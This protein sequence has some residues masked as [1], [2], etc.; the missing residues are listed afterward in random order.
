MRSA[1]SEHPAGGVDPALSLGEG[2]TPVVRLPALE[3]H[4][5]GARLWCKAEHLN[6]TGSYKD[7]LAVRAVTVARRHGLSGILGTSSGNGAAAIA[8]YGARAGLP[9]RILT[10]PGAPAA[11]L[12]GASAAGARTLPVEGL[13]ITPAETDRVF[14]KVL[15]VADELGLYPFITAWSFAPDMMTG[16]CGISTELAHQRPDASVVY[17]PVG[18]GGLL[19]S[20]WRGFRDA[21]GPRPRVVGVQPV[22][23]A[24]LRRA[25]DG[26]LSPLPRVTTTVSGLQVAR[27]LDVEGATEAVTASGGHVV[28]ITDEQAF[29][30][31]AMLARDGLLVEPAGAVALAGALADARAGRLGPDDEAVVIA[32]GAGWKDSTS[33]QRVAGEPPPTESVAVADLPAALAREL[34]A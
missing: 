15:E 30:A 19:T 28:E 5:G 4:V 1:L 34:S 12:L 24:T 27:L 8:A 21:A 23:S 31:Q 14:A 25:C 13:G 22:G 10:V 33:L 18:G 6:P 29:E 26:D 3:E 2:S 7:R 11:K 20:V 17:V 16:A 32:S 9:V